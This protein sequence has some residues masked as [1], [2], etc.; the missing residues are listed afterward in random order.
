MGINDIRAKIFTRIQPTN[1]V[2]VTTLKEYIEKEFDGN[3][4]EFSRQIG[5]H[6]QQV[7]KWLLMDAIVI[8]GEI[9]QNKSNL[10]NGR[11]PQGKLIV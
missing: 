2:P 4:S 6:R 9:Y 11:G 1:L 8:N 7:A 10:F 3:A 5:K